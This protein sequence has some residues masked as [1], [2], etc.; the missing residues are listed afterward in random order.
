MKLTLDFEAGL[1]KAF[2]M[3]QRIKVKKVGR[4]WQL[5]QFLKPKVTPIPV[6]ILRQKL[7]LTLRY[8]A[9]WCFIQKLY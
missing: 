9:F 6:C 3:K 2:V 1:T 7:K 8:T 5:V 4:T